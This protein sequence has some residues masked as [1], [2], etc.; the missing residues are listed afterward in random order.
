MYPGEKSSSNTS[1]IFTNESIIFLPEFD[2]MSIARLSLEVLFAQKYRLWLGFGS[3][4]LKGPKLRS[5]D[6]F[7]GSIFMTL[8]P[9]SPISLPINCPLSPHIS[10]TVNPDNAVMRF[11]PHKKSLSHQ[12]IPLTNPSISLEYVRQVKVKHFLIPM[13]FLT[14]S[15]E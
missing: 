15:L 14:F 9:I 8:A 11:L 7:L 6:P 13:V 2:S 10:M 3:S 4:F 12:E 1:D 5:F